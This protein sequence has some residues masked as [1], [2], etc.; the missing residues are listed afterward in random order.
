LSAGLKP[1]SAPV[2][3]ARDADAPDPAGGRRHRTLRREITWVLIMKLAALTLLWLAFFSPSHR[4]QVDGR[5]V[6]ERLG[7]NPPAGAPGS[8]PARR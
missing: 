4:P 2:R 6:G 3:G 1:A 5:T 8:T 7:A